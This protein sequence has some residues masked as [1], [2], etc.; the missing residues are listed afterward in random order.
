[1]E[2]LGK[3]ITYPPRFGAYTELYAG[4]STQLDIEQDQGRW[5]VPWGRKDMPMRADIVAETQKAK[6]MSVQIY[7]WCDGITRDWQ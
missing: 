2:L 5:V 3:A 6:G 4:L 1:M 7:D